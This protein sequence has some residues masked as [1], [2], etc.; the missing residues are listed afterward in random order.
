MQ[1]R[2]CAPLTPVYLALLIRHARAR[3]EDDERD[4]LGA[5]AIGW[6]EMS[7]E[8]LEEQRALAQVGRFRGIG[9]IAWGRSTPVFWPWGFELI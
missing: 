8:E 5:P 6:D 4:G 9:R 2:V 3:A 1:R 7:H